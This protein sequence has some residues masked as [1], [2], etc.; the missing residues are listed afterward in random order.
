V[1]EM[2]AQNN[3][4]NFTNSKEVRDIVFQDNYA[5][6]A[7]SGGLMKLDLTNDERY[8][9]DRSNSGIPSNNISRLCIDS[10]NNI[11]VGTYDAGV[12]VFD[13]SKWECYSEDFDLLKSNEILSLFTDS[14]GIVWIGT[15]WDLYRYYDGLLHKDWNIGGIIQ[16]ITEDKNGAIWIGTTGALLRISNGKLK[17]WGQVNKPIPF[18]N[19]SNLAV[20]T[21]N[22]VWILA[23]EGL[24][25]YDDGQFDKFDINSID[26]PN[27]II[28]SLTVDNQ[29]NLWLASHGRIA[30]YNGINFEIFNSKNS[31][32]S[33][34]R[35][36]KIKVDKS[37]NIWACTDNGLYKYDYGG[38]QFINTKTSILNSKQSI[39]IFSDSNNNVWLVDGSDL[40]IFGRDTIIHY[41]KSNSKFKGAYS[42]AFDNSGQVWIGHSGG[43]TMFD[44]TN[45]KEIDTLQSILLNREKELFN[46]Y[47]DTVWVEKNY[48]KYLIDSTYLFPPQ[49]YVTKLTFDNMGNLWLKASDE[50][51]KYG[52][53]SW[54]LYDTTNSKITTTS[55]SDLAFDFKNNLWIGTYSNGLIKYDGEKCLVYDSTNAIIANRI[56]SLSIFNDSLFISTTK[57]TALFDGKN[58]IEIFMGVRTNSTIK[59]K[60]GNYW[61]AS[62]Q[63]LIN[64]NQNGYGKYY[65]TM[66]SGLADNYIQSICFDFDG[67]LWILSNSG[68]NIYNE[69]GIINEERIRN[70]FTTF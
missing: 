13:G 44:G 29:N 12:A 64:P 58:W 63:G 34:T 16:A 25:T 52:S 67:N 30:K 47:K 17:F 5:W 45:W 14:K 42:I 8:L 28:S 49:Y 20:G 59:D 26:F 50:L 69:N 27:G 1:K 61:I 23:K 7:T 57:G 19:V 43:L 21:D 4:L 32:L 66:N 54:T 37:N 2:S 38:W 46:K 35:I 33:G 24:I 3:W 40:Y 65:S 51:V 39:K 70:F 62:S 22:K 10:S 9:Y 48:K 68:I 31:E 15:R 55:I 56:N 60:N 11:W 6:V 41:D 18:F 53:M 36:N